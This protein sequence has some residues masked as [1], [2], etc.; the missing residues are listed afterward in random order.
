VTTL[1]FVDQF[2]RV[3]IPPA[4]GVEMRGETQEYAGEAPTQAGGQDVNCTA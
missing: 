1:R 3:K 2:E 4:P